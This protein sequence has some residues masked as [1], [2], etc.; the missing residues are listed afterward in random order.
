MRKL[1]LDLSSSTCGYAITEDGNIITCGFFDISKHTTYKEKANVIISGL[2]GKE[3]DIINVEENLFGFKSGQ[4]SQKTI[5]TLVKNKVVICYILEEYYKKPM[6]YANATTMRK[7]LFGK[8]RR[9]GIKPKVF[10]KENIEQKYDMSK[11]V[12][13]NRDKNPDARMAD[14]Y[15]AVVVSVY[16]PPS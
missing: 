16:T 15:D 10:V 12:I 3:F 4:S 6:Y 13:L 14:V 2:E 7:Q 1:G 5:I 11:W 9:K 8:A